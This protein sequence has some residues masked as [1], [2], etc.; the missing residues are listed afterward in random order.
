MSSYLGRTSLMKAAAYGNTE[1][2]KILLEHGADINTKD[3]DGK[4]H[5]NTSI[6]KCY[7]V[8]LLEDINR[9][10]NNVLY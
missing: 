7:G 2:V 3:N 5:T 8:M 10:T 9:P 1:T 4:L 6:I